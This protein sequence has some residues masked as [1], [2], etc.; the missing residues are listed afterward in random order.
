[1]C[2]QHVSYS[3][4]V[5]CLSFSN[6]LIKSVW[7]KNFDLNYSW[8]EIIYF[9]NNIWISYF[10]FIEHNLY[11]N[12]FKNLTSIFN[13]FVLHFHSFYYIIYF[14]YEEITLNIAFLIMF[15]FWFFIKNFHQLWP[16]NQFCE[17]KSI[18]YVVCNT[19]CT[20]QILYGKT[21]KKGGLG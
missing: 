20:V 6:F 5:Y 7:S 10:L 2:L 18:I 16:G 11:R 4:H 14:H 17:T 3:Y 19:T 13:Y 21:R 9:S 15:D 8:V 12:S 1:M